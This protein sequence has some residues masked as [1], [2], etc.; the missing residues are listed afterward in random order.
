[1]RS[2]PFQLLKYIFIFAGVHT[3]AYAFPKV[4]IVTTAV[5][6]VVNEK[7]HIEPGLGKL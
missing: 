4:K 2:L 5:D 3:V 1:M 7:F 6:K